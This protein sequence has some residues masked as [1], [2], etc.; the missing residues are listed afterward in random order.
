ML[1]A[2]NEPPITNADC[3]HFLCALMIVA[4]PAPGGSKEFSKLPQLAK[5]HIF[6]LCGMAI[7]EIVKKAVAEK[8]S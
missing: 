3:E 8:S 4:V 6:P 5:K 2:I 7:N 1:I